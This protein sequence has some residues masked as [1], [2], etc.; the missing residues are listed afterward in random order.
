MSKQLLKSTTG[1]NLAVLDYCDT[2]L[3]RKLR[4]HFEREGSWRPQYG[5]HKKRLVPASNPSDW[6]ANTDD[7]FWTVCRNKT[8]EVVIENAI[9]LKGELTD[10]HLAH[11]VVALSV[12]PRTRAVG[13]TFRVTR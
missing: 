8:C 7:S 9:G 6:A 12:A 11:R 13:C 3:M 5:W 10:E 1:Q 4:A 2:Y